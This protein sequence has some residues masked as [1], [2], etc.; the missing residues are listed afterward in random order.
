MEL[1]NISL[2]YLGVVSS[3]HQKFSD[4]GMIVSGFQ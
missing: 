1:L 2:F 3:Q 4:S